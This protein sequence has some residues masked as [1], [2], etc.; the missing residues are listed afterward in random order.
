MTPHRQNLAF[1]TLLRMRRYKPD[2]R[3]VS[4]KIIAR[5]RAEW[6]CRMLNISISELIGKTREMRVVFARFIVSHHLYEE[7]G[8]SLTETGS[9]FGRTHAS[10]INH[11]KQYDNL[12]S[13]KNKA[14]MEMLDK[15]K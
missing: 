11:L 6:I 15:V 14:F 2:Q 9:V 1:E 3:P 5:E 13:T 10:I 8:L 4:P 7:L 12:K